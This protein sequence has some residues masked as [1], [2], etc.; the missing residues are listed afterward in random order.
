MSNWWIIITPPKS[1]ISPE[2]QCLEF[3]I[4]FGG[5][6]FSGAYVSF[7][8]FWECTP[9]TKKKRYERSFFIHRWFENP[10]Y[11]QKKSSK[12]L[13][14]SFPWNHSGW[15]WSSFTVD[16]V[17]YVPNCLRWISG[18]PWI[19]ISSCFWKIAFLVVIN[20]LQKKKLPSIRSSDI[21]M[22]PSNVKGPEK[23]PL[24]DN[25]NSAR[26]MTW[27][28]LI[29]WSNIFLYHR[30]IVIIGFLEGKSRTPKVVLPFHPSRVNNFL[31]F[32]IFP[33]DNTPPIPFTKTTKNNGPVAFV[34]SN[35]SALVHA[36]TV[37][38]NDSL[39][40]IE[41][42]SPDLCELIMRGGYYKLHP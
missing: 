3:L 14:S 37:P 38:N 30:S 5:G 16:S 27:Q 28:S 7:M 26:V 32:R 20:S 9:P 2:N 19:W 10:G 15:R 34:P 31:E 4:S 36:P 13:F 42:G 17:H 12:V 6:L 18:P 1:N 11:V 35:I 21:V 8:Y 33:F 40:R 24:E 22:S 29:H 41:V 23:L 39:T 25:I